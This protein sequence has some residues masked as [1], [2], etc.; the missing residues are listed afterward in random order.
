MA[1]GHD[2]SDAREHGPGHGVSTMCFVCS[3]GVDKNTRAWFRIE[4]SLLQVASC[5]I[6]HKNVS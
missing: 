6:L 2:C 4:L 1:A 3:H 5:L